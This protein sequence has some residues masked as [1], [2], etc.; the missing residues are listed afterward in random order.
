MFAGTIALAC[1]AAGL[2]LTFFAQLSHERFV[3]VQRALGVTFAIAALHAFGV[4]GV[5]SFTPLLVVLAVPTAVALAAFAHRSLLTTL[6]ARRHRY[7]VAA[8]N[9][10]D[11]DVVEIRLQ[12]VGRGD[13]VHARAVH[14]HRLPLGRGRA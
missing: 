4:P 2:A 14:L 8:V 3:L 11:D 9:R 12:P 5:R 7:V 13:R 6:L 10:L 1:M